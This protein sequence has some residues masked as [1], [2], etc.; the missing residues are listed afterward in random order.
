MDE[1]Q[2]LYNLYKKL[3]GSK[4][5]RTLTI[6]D[7]TTGFRTSEITSTDE[8]YDIYLKNEFHNGLYIS[9]YEYDTPENITRWL[10]SD[11]MKFEESAIKNCVVLRFR[12]DIK[13]IKEEISKLPQIQKFMFI[14]RSINLGHLNNAIKEA[15]KT[16][17]F[18]KEEFGYDA[19][20]IYNGFNECS[21]YIKTKELHLENPTLTMFALNRII[22]D[23]MKL[24]TLFYKNIE[25]YSQMISLPG[26]QNTYTK[27]YTK[28]FE[29]DTPYEEIIKNSS[30]R[31]MNDILPKKQKNRK[32]SDIITKIDKRVSYNIS[33]GNTNKKGYTLE[34]IL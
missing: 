29:I 32:I 30:E 31:K 28:P 8:I 23:H 19:F 33:Q 21:L 24:E 25:P 12:E 18:I 7:T 17:Q 27:L 1:D 16:H 34:E 5:K 3:Y 15:K 14:R 11:G 20:P 9:V 2:N 4:F 13:M 26:G 22:E 10:K 6:G